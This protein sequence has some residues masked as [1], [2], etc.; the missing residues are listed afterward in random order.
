ME[1]TDGHQLLKE[2]GGSCAMLPVCSSA[3]QP[4]TAL[5]GHTIHSDEPVSGCSHFSASDLFTILKFVK[6]VN[7]RAEN[8]M[9]RT[10]RLEGAHYM[11]MRQ[12]VEDCRSALRK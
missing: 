7:R 2:P 10:G 9:L 5:G 1:T 3:E 12:I 4:D 6:E 11:A 8:N